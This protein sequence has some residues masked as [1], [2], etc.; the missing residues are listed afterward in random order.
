MSPQQ[1]VMEQVMAAL[2]RLIARKARQ[3]QAAAAVAK[4]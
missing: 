3:K 1:Q 4:G 2:A